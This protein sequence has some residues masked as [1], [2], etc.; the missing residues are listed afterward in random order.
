MGYVC[1][2][3]HCRL[4]LYPW[5]SLL[6]KQNFKFLHDMSQGQIKMANKCA[7]AYPGFLNHLN[8][9]QFVA[10][11]RAAGKCHQYLVRDKEREGLYNIVESH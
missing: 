8:Q 7:R 9:F 2:N 3:T 11:H 1:T 6:L 10:L 4:P 5:L